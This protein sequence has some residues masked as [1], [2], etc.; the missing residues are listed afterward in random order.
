MKSRLSE[1]KNTQKASTADMNWPKKE[2]GD[3]K[4]VNLD[5]SNRGTERKK[6]KERE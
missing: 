6:E 5:D 1:T 3:L 4:Q 2:Q